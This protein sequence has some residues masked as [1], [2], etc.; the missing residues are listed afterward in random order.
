M[1]FKYDIVFASSTPLTVGVPG[2]FGRILRRKKFVFEVRDLWPELPKEMGVIKN[3]IILSILSFL[4][5]LIYHSANK[6]IA[7]SPGISLESKKRNKKK[8][9]N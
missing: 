5:Y 7:L 9:S 1:T 3:P 4:E 2:I 8:Y 6:L